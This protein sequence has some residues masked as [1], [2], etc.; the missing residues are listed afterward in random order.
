MKRIAVIGT[1]SYAPNKILTNAD[2]EKM[3]DTTDEWITQRTGIKER[4]ISDKD[5][6]TS[7]LA[8]KAAERALEAAKVKAE[9]LDFIACGTVTPDMVFPSM[10]CIVQAKIGAV[11]AAAFDI[12]AGCTGFVYGMELARS[13][14]LA[15]PGRKVLLIG[16]EELTKI[17]DWTDRSSCVLF[18]DGAGAVVLA[19]VAE[20]RGI[21]STFLGA[22][23]NLGDLIYQPGGGS[24][25]PASHETVDGKM[26]V[27][28]MAGNKVFPHAVRKMGDAATKVLDAAGVSQN[29]L[30]VLIPHQAN[31]RII[32]AIGRQ[33]NLPME[34]VYV[35]IERYGN[36]SSASIPIALDEAVRNG[37]ITPGKY[38]MLVAFGAGL[39]WG[40]ILMRW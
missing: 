18:G 28:R 38:V 26:H 14:I 4:H 2:L 6:P 33:L 39:T 20:D 11:K 5:T 19:E 10:A 36:T 16:A 29:Q 30:D 21:L 13:L 8:V 34:K 1:G 3:V 12:L 17:T 15:D 7:V 22:D 25:R 35:N 32:D 37:R 27:I 40:A 31:L 23:G 9:E 24:L